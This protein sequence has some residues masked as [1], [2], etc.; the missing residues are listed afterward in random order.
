MPYN[1]HAAVGVSKPDPIKKD[2]IKNLNSFAVTGFL[3][4]KKRVCPLISI[5][6]Y[7]QSA[8]RKKEKT[9]NRRIAKSF[10]ERIPTSASYHGYSHY[11]FQTEYIKTS[12]FKWK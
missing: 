8:T 9:L 1:C 7:H 11:R 4:L 5:N 12:N 2:F 10:K 6:R 3:V